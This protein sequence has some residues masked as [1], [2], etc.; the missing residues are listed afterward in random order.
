MALEEYVDWTF[1]KSIASPADLYKNLWT[2]KR[3]QTY[4]LC[5]LLVL[6]IIGLFA[7]RRG[8]DVIDGLI[9]Y[10]EYSILALAIVVYSVEPIF[11]LVQ[12]LVF[13][14]PPV[15]GAGSEAETTGDI[16][17]VISCHRSADVVVRTVHACMKHLRPNQIFVMDNANFPDPPDNTREVLEEADLHEVNYIYNPYGNKTLA[18]YG[19]VVAAKDF[20]YLLLIDDDVTLPEHMHFGKHLFNDTVKAVC[21]PIL[22]VH[23]ETEECTGMF[24][25]WQAIEYKMSDYSKLLQNEFS[26]VLFPHG[27][28]CLWERSTLIDCFRAHDTVFY[29]DDVKVSGGSWRTML[30]Q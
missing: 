2:S 25:E 6:I 3:K 12:S 30:G 1:V 5:Y 14:H 24:I 9:A 8:D 7:L 23:P 10:I 29:A 21:Y 13:A 20:K 16:A 4:V 27:A 15:D 26:T 22:A 28:I 19:G 17:V 18:M 11:L